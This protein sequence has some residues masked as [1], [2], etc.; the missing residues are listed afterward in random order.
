MKKILMALDETKTLLQGFTSI[1]EVILLTEH[2]WTQSLMKRLTLETNEVM[3][4]SMYKI[5]NLILPSSR[6]KSH[7]TI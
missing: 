7:N 2:Y 6:L 3:Q 1:G 5:E 4:L